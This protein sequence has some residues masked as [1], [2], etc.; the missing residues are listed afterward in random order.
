MFLLSASS[1]LDC[2]RGMEDTEISKI[3][4]AKMLAA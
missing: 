1:E 3:S 4:E 2:N